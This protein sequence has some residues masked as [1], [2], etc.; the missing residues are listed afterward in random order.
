MNYQSFHELESTSSAFLFAIVCKWALWQLF[1]S[2]LTVVLFKINER[3]GYTNH[4][5]DF[6]LRIFQAFWLVCFILIWLHRCRDPWPVWHRI[7]TLHLIIFDFWVENFRN[8]CTWPPH[9]T[10][11]ETFRCLMYTRNFNFTVIN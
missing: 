11:G 1:F 6:I 5:H 4:I 10:D 7:P 2:N 8:T 3:S 9:I